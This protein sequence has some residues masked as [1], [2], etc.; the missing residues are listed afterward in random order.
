MS[1]IRFPHI[2]IIF[3]FLT[4]SL[5]SFLTRPFFSIY[6]FLFLFWILS[7]I[8]TKSDKITNTII[9]YTYNLLFS[10]IP[11]ILITYYRFDVLLDFKRIILPIF[12]SIAGYWGGYFAFRKIDNPIWRQALLYSIPLFIAT[13]LLGR[14]GWP[15]QFPINGLIYLFAAFY[16]STNNLKHNIRIFLILATPV[17]LIYDL[18]VFYEG[19]IFVLP[20]A[21]NLP[22]CIIVGIW[23]KSLHS[24]YPILSKTIII[25]FTVFQI[26]GYFGMKN[27][28][29]YAS[30]NDIPSDKEVLSSTFGMQDLE[31]SVII[32][33]GY[34]MDKVTV[35]EFWTTSCGVCFRRFPDL[36][37]VYL[38]YKNHPDFQLE[39]INL[40][41]RH[42]H[43]DSTKSIIR[44]WD[45][46]FPTLIADSSYYYYRKLFNL[47][48]VP[49]VLIFN[50]QGEL[51]Y[52][53]RL[54]NDPNV[55]YGNISKTLDKLLY[56]NK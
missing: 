35:W 19:S 34:F 15:L 41:T 27:W 54:N 20:I 38:K 8:N 26:S 17:I 50:K 48:G 9:S 52:N 12:C 29:V 22:L 30:Q 36:D 31:K 53:G 5:L 16:F 23:L 11:H 6:Y 33:P 3:T 37:E 51:I 47:K 43:I 32:N 55:P 42:D 18:L 56:D 1:N 7:H 25:L 39:S 10:I 13:A 14:F 21:I 44:N 28:L 46:S 2:S 4:V 45:Y 40:P 49:A 24:R